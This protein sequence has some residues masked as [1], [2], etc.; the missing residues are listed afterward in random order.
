MNDRPSS[1]TVTYGFIL[2]N[3]II[4]F[5]L[6][7]IIAFSLHPAMPDQP[8][9]KGIM[10]TL[11]LVAAGVLLVTLIFLQK[12]NRVAYFLM[13]ISLGVATLLTFFDDFGLVDLAALSLS[14]I[15]LILLIKD[16]QW[17]LVS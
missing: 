5:V 3:I 9:F 1:V 12:H 4:W 11:S 15:P 14:L 16:R 13:L 2:L 6:G 17:Y 10:T 8:L 7:I